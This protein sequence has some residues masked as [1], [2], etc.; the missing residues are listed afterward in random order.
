MEIG[1]QAACDLSRMAGLVRYSSQIVSNGGAVCVGVSGAESVPG[2]S[3]NIA[4]QIS[5]PRSLRRE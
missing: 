3:L 4:N 1:R 2:S 5:N